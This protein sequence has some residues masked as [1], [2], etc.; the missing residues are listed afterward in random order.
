M[1]LIPHPGVTSHHWPISP[2]GRNSATESSVIFRLRL[3]VF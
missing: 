1:R 2:D 3:V